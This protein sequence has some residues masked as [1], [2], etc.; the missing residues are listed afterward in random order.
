MKT[1]LEKIH[2]RFAIVN[3]GFDQVNL[4]GSVGAV[5]YR[6]VGGETIA[7]Q[8][9]PPKQTFKPTW[10]L[11]YRRMLWPNLVTLFRLINVVGW[12]PSFMGKAPRVSDFNAFMARNVSNPATRVF[13]EKGYQQSGSAVAVPVVV[14]EGNLPPVSLTIGENNVFVSN[15][16]VGGLVIGASTTVGSFSDA[17]V[18]GNP[19][20]KNKDQLS[21]L[22]LRQSVDSVSGMPMVKAEHAKVVLDVDDEVNLL[23]DTGLNQM[24]QVADGYLVFAGVVVG[25]AAIIHSR[26]VVGGETMV[27]TQSLTMNSTILPVYQ[28]LQAFENAAESY[29]GVRSAQYLTPRSG[30]DEVFPQA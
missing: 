4:R 3:R 12:H 9:V 7:S 29:G 1:L 22:I 23:S 16:A 28:T 13:L 20:W 21:V 24:L 6:R 8:K 18:S 11:M 15:I 10:S 25:G 5:T 26:D 19:D 27:S 14:S 17:I 2:A 30:A